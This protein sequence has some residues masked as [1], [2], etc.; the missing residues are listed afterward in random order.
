MDW[1][2][3]GLRINSKSIK[4]I[5]GNIYPPA[6]DAV[7]KTESF[8]WHEGIL[9]PH[10]SQALAVD[11]FGTL[12]SLGQERRNAVMSAFAS[13]LGVSDEGPWSVELEWLDDKNRLNE[14]RWT[15]V[16]VLLRGSKA[17]FCVECKFTESAGG[18][19]SQTKKLNRGKHKGEVQCDGNYEP[20]AN[21]VNGLRPRCSL[22]GKGIR[23]WD[24]IPDVFSYSAEEEYRP[25]PFAGAEYQWMR[26]IV[27]A[28]VVAKADGCRPAFVLM[29]ADSPAFHIP[30][31][32]ESV[33]WRDFT[34]TIRTETITARAVSF[35]LFI[36]MANEALNE[37]ALPSQEWS[38]LLGWVI[39]KID[40]AA[41]TV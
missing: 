27:L 36:E 17:I 30:K 22:T 10:S 41:N 11:V 18:A 29:Y 33:A 9:R 16:D 13:S 15:Q 14:K 2:V 4:L 1:G 40:K 35:Q 5:R 38:G 24:L 20:Q 3:Y 7:S 6:W 21:P 23:Y 25:C 39:G 32:I 8:P 26:N 12:K 31:Y 37:A 34:S 28:N 19:C